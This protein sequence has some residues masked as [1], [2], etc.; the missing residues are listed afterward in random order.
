MIDRIHYKSRASKLVN[1]RQ[2]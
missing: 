1:V 2:Q